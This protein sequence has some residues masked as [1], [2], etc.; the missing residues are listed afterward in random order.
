MTIVKLEV[1]SFSSNV[2]YCLSFCY[3]G[4]SRR[5]RKRYF[6]VQANFFPFKPILF[7]CKDT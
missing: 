3:Y 6:C 5:Q 7:Q 2:S 1:N 4:L